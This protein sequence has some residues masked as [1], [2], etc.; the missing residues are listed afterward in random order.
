[1]LSIL[2]DGEVLVPSSEQ[3]VR[4]LVLS[5][6]AA[7]LSYGNATVPTIREYA[8]SYLRARLGINWILWTLE[9][10]GQNTPELS[11][12]ASI[13]S[14]IN[15][16]KTNKARLSSPDAMNVLHRMEDE[17]VKTIA[18]KK[19]IGSNIVEFARHALGQRETANDALRG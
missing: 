19:G 2:Q 7:Y 9:E 1:M 11:S 15:A 4:D 12:A 6:D 13:L 14:L 5:S 16:V 17:E 10:V 3:Q 8:S 18:C